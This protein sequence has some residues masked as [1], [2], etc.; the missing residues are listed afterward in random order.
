MEAQ[1]LKLITDYGIAVVGL[2]FVT[3]FLIWLI[4]YMVERNKE[5]EDCFLRLMTDSLKGL[6]DSMSMLT[7]NL[8]NM[9][10]NVSEAHKFQ[11]EEHAKLTENQQK[12]NEVLIEL[13]KTI[14][15]CR[16]FTIGDI[17]TLKEKDDKQRN[18]SAS[19]N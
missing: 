18:I 16:V 13:N 1:S 12:T 17:V 15:R 10:Q 9:S 2:Y 8:N 11:R 4:K 14:E 6:S 19:D 5:R 7:T 3:K